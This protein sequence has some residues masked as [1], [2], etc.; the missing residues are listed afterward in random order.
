M[1][2]TPAA[3]S[4]ARA[5]SGARARRPAGAWR[6]VPRAAPRAPAP[7][8]AAAHRDDVPVPRRVVP[9]SGPS[10]LPAL[11]ADLAR[12]WRWHATVEVLADLGV[13]EPGVDADSPDVR[14][15]VGEVGPARGRPAPESARF[16]AAVS[17]GGVDDVKARLSAAAQ[18]TSREAQVEQAANQAVNR[19]ALSLS[20]Y[21]EVPVLYKSLGV[22]QPTWRTREI[23]GLGLDPTAEADK[24]WY[25]DAT[26]AE[27]SERARSAGLEHVA[28][29]GEQLPEAV[30]EL[31]TTQARWAGAR[32]VRDALIRE[33]YPEQCNQPQLQALTGLGQAQVWQIINPD[34]RQR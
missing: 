30:R 8:P 5:S 15:V 29:A 11:D 31:I 18:R 2:P 3:T 27:L 19:L 10:R 6:T 13:L 4:T 22:A 7:L 25:R 21:D 23:R 16:L 9:R 17:A 34:F 28:G 24:A 32:R 26:S 33:L 14:A 20:L 1:T 12:R